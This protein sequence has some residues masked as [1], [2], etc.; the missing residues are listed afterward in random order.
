MT[1]EL[2]QAFARIVNA[3]QHGVNCLPDFA[4]ES[5]ANQLRADVKALDDYLNPKDAP[6]QATL[7]EKPEG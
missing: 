6:A 3:A 7:P 2:E 1:T 5:A 4:K